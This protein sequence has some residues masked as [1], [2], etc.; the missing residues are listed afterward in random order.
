MNPSDG[1][2]IETGVLEGTIFNDDVGVNSIAR[3]TVTSQGQQTNGNVTGA[4]MSGD[5]RYVVFASGASNIVNGDLNDK[6][7]IFL[8]DLELG[9]TVLASITPAGGFPDDHSQ[10]PAISADGSYLAY[11]HV[12]GTLVAG[13]TSD[14]DII[15]TQ[16]ATLTHSLASLSFS[17]GDA[18]LGPAGF[19]ALSEDGR[20]VAFTSRAGQ[21]CHRRQQRSNRRVRV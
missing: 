6:E 10:F 20:F 14:A 19:S 11:R 1:A 17:G 21:P 9:T 15:L 8:R 13:D 3:V 16:R 5:G 18:N 4:A 7:D 2:I 12:S